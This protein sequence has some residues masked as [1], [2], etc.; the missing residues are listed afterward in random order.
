[1]KNHHGNI[2]SFA[3][4]LPAALP[5]CV[6]SSCVCIVLIFETSSSSHVQCHIARQRGPLGP[7][8][9]FGPC[10]AASNHEI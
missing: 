5:G 4:I 10:L 7:E 9:A 2:H 8:L 1:M 3:L 6:I